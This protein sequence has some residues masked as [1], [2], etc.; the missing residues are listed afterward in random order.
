MDSIWLPSASKNF[1]CVQKPASGRRASGGSFQTGARVPFVFLRQFAAAD[2]AHD[3]ARSG[4]HSGQSECDHGTRQPEAGRY[5]PVPAQPAAAIDPWSAPSGLASPSLRDVRDRRTPRPPRCRGSRARTRASQ[6]LR[7]SARPAD[8]AP[9]PRP[10]PAACAA[11][12]RF[13]GQ[14]GAS[15]PGRSSRIP[16]GRNCTLGSA[17][18]GRAA[19]ATS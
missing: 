19:R 14:C 8:M 15:V 7:T 11:P 5:G 6:S 2:D 12:T 10:A 3:A 13:A 17:A 9:A 1:G 4:D 18:R 16:R